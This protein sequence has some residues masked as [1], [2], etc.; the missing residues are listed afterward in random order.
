MQFYLD[1]ANLEEI[2]RAAEMG[3]I[4]GVTTN[5]TLMAREGLLDRKKALQE[6]CFRV[7]GPISIEVLGTTAEE[8]VEEAVQITRWSPNAVVKIPM[9]AE[10]LKAIRRLKGM[11]VET[12][13]VCEGCP[14]FGACHTD[15][16]TAADLVGFQ[17]VR[18]NCTLIFSLPQA[19]LA[20]HAGA[21]FVSPFIGRLDDIGEDGIGLV[22]QIVQAFRQGGI[23]TRVLAASIRHP[24]H[25]VEAAEAG[26]DIATMPFKVLMQLLKHP[27]TD[28]GVERFLRDWE[29]AKAKVE[30][31]VR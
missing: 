5:P 28:L 2:A 11:D 26:A 19:L 29:A 13:G 9:T 1:T 27:L 24:R 31:E 6:I 18:V 17:G 7:N 3:V 12:D 8:M 23:E 22:R 10:G 20:A 4:Q 25:V 14:H 15:P 21:D 30:G 16:Q